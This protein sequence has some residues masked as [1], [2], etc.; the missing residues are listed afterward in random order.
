MLGEQVLTY[1]NYVDWGYVYHGIGAKNEQLIERWQEALRIFDEAEAKGEALESERPSAMLHRAAIQILRRDEKAIRVIEDGV[2]LSQRRLTP[3]HEVKLLLLRVVAEL[4]WGVHAPSPTLMSWVDLAQD[5]AVTAAAYRS[6]WTVFYTRARLET[7]LGHHARAIES[8][9]I[10][11]EQLAKVLNDPRMEERYAPFYEDLAIT[12]R[13]LRHPIGSDVH[14]LIRNARIRHE[15]SS[16][17]A[18]SDAAFDDFLAGYRPTATYHD[19]RFNLP[20]P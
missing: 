4:A 1:K 18:M 19:G 5:R 15:V 14:A 11:L 10:A 20:V 13:S 9:G 8:F 7:M 2:R 3:F 16:I 12:M 6:Y 17:D